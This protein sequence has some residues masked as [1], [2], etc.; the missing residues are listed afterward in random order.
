MWVNNHP[1]VDTSH[2]S[3]IG[4]KAVSPVFSR[5]EVIPNP[6]SD[7]VNAFIDL[8]TTASTV[9]YSIVDNSGHTVVK[10]VHTNVMNDTYKYPTTT[11]ASGNYYLIVNVDGKNVFRSFTVIK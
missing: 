10:E 8:Y 7:Y 2:H 3:N 1:V 9:T 5:F 6:A 4:V 11:L